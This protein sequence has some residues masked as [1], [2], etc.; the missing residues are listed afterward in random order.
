MR[1]A[2]QCDEDDAESEAEEENSDGLQKGELTEESDPSFE[3]SEAE[4]VENDSE[5][6]EERTDQHRVSHWSRM[7]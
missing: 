5:N 1:G 3:S 2:N 6:A 7:Q 4:A